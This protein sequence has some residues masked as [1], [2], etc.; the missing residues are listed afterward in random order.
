MKKS[1]YFLLLA[2]GTIITIFISPAF[3]ADDFSWDMFLPSISGGGKDC[4]SVKNGTAS[5]DKCGIC[6]SGTTGKIACV[7]DCNGDWG[8]NAVVDP[9]GV[10]GGTGKKPC[11]QDN[12]CGRT[13]PNSLI[14][15]GALEW[16]RCDPSGDF[17][18]NDAKQYC[19]DLHMS[20]HTDWRLPTKDELK[21]IVWCSTGYKTPLADPPAHPF[22]CGD[23]TS[24]EPEEPTIIPQL[25]GYSKR[26]WTSTVY[27]YDTNLYYYVSFENGA[28]GTMPP[29]NRWMG[30]RCVR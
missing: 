6:V 5:R 19:E 25:S 29:S 13:P 30:V 15:G 27:P 7:Q 8:G 11:G 16:Q 22:H 1:S 20:G 9:C 24:E 10:C 18:W 14:V 26:V 4:N 2:I 3:G 21:T 28:T 12:P 17:R 23:G